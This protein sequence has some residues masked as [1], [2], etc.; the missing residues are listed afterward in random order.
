VLI[1]AAVMVM[2]TATTPTPLTPTAT[3]STPVA[4]PAVR[5]PLPGAILPSGPAEVLPALP[6]AG[7]VPTSA[8]LGKSIGPLLTRPA[9]GRSVSAEVVDVITGASL[10]TKDAV[11]AAVPASTAKVLTAAAAFTALGPDTTLA[12][13]VVRGAR[14]GEIFLLGGGD[15]LLAPGHG[16]P[17]AVLGHA[18]LADLADAT[19]A[20]LRAEG[21]TSVAV[22]L[23][24]T[25]FSGPAVNPAWLPDDVRRGFVAPVMAVEVMAGVARPAALPQ[26]ATAPARR[27]GTAARCRTAGGVIA[28]NGVGGRPRRRADRFRQCG[29]PASRAYRVTLA[30]ATAMKY[31]SAGGSA[32]GRR[33][34][35]GPGRAILEQT[36][37][38]PDRRCPAD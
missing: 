9:L 20:S 11:R 10:F 13:R 26:P 6:T 8:G 34:T 5:L 36:R 7:P 2:A 33:T 23:D 29:R 15:V 21:T 16:D 38:G 37:L 14:L 17:R 24:D 32:G 18:G 35:R 31:G 27:S 30:T 12:T 28:V 19:A 1:S 3:T 25:L 4:M 22:R